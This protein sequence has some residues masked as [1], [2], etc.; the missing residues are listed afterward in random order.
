MH[1]AFVSSAEALHMK[2]PVAASCVQQTSID[3]KLGHNDG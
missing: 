3:I 2:V 1:V